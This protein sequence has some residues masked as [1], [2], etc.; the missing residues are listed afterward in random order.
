M[1]DWLN[2]LFCVWLVISDLCL[3]HLIALLSPVANCSKSVLSFSVD[4]VTTGTYNFLSFILNVTFVGLLITATAE[5]ASGS[6]SLVAWLVNTKF[7]DH[8]KYDL[9]RC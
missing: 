1:L 9:F 5:S 6:A 2:N 3:F 8:V 7:S 4:K